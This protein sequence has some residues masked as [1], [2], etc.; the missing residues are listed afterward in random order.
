MRPPHS[1][2]TVPAWRLF[3]LAVAAAVG[4]LAIALLWFAAATPDLWLEQPAPA[5][6]EIGAADIP[7][8]D[9]AG[10][11]AVSRL[12]LAGPDGTPIEAAVSRPLINEARMPVII[13]IGGFDTGERSVD[14]VVEPGANVVIG[15]GDR[16]STRLNSSH[17]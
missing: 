17:G 2:R 8:R 1:Y 5:A 3:A 12:N 10:G 16:K 14:R 7:G 4:I 13:L 6:L 15:Y 11:R 9:D